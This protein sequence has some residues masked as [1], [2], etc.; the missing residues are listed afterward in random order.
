MSDDVVLITSRSVFERT[1]RRLFAGA[2]PYDVTS[3]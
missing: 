2:L 1:I 3:L